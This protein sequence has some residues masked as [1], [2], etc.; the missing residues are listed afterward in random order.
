ML[1]ALDRLGMA[2]NTL[3]MFTADHGIPFPRAKCSLY[4]PGLE[5]PLIVRWPAGGIEG[6]RVEDGM[7]SHVDVL[8]TLGEMLGLSLPG[9]L[10][11]ESF[12]S[13]WRGEDHRGRDVLFAEMTYHDYY[14]PIRVVRTQRHKLMVH[15]MYNVG[16]MDPSQ[17]WDRLSRSIV[18]PHPPHSRH[19]L[20]EL[21]NLQ[22]DPLELNDLA[23]DPAHADL[24]AELLRQLAQWMRD[25]DD[26][27]M[28]GVP[29]AP[30]HREALDALGLPQP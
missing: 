18:T 21:Y 4:D 19:G 27:I 28:R 16:F 22:A 10:H 24:R 15:F 29:L 12:A 8:P 14:D 17:Q 7:I 3:F 20:V 1:D 6:G 25:T 30:M 11:G 13:T 2:D 9:N 5:V 26:P 23:N